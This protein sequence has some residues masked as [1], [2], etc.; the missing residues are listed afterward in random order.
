ME[1]FQEGNPRRETTF[2]EVEVGSIDEACRKSFKTGEGGNDE[3]A[4]AGFCLLA[5]VQ[6]PEGTTS[7]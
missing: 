4:H 6:D 1:V 2:L 3:E 7:D 5:I